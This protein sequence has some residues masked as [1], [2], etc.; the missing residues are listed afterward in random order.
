MFIDDCFK[1]GGLDFF[2]HCNPQKDA[3][4]IDLA[5]GSTFQPYTALQR[6]GH[7][8]NEM[9]TTAIKLYKEYQFM[10]GCYLGLNFG[11]KLNISCFRSFK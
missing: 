8:Q 2:L 3:P 11:S 1:F 9:A 5:H 4:F 6:H 7:S 10:C